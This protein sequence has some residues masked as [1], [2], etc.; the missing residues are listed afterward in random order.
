[1]KKNQYNDQIILKYLIFFSFLIHLTSINFFP[2]NFEGGYGQYSDLFNAENKILYLK[3]YYSSQFNTYIFSALGSVLNFFIPFID[4]F[5]SIKII[6]A[7]SYFF[8]G[9][10]LLNILKFYKYKYNLTFFILIIFLNSIIWSYGFRAFN[11]LFAFSLAI[12][13]LSRILKNHNNKIVFLD[14]ILLGFS[15][16][17]KSYNLILLIPLLIFFFTSDN[18]EKKIN[19]IL[20]IFVIIFLPIILLNIF[21]YN[22]LGFILAPPN[23]DVQIAIIGND[24]NRDI[25]WVI[26]NF[27]FYVGY[28]TLISLPFIFISFLS[29]IKK[30]V[31]KTLIFLLI[32]FLLSF[33]FQNFFFISSELDL[34]PFQSFIP[35]KVYKA[36]IVFLF[37]FFS[38]FL[39]FFLKYEKLTQKQSNICKTIILTILLYLFV[40]SFIKAAQRYLILPLPF[41]YL[42]IFSERQ[43]KLLIYITLIFYISINSLLLA[44]YYIVGKSTKIIFNFLKS[45]QLLE[46]TIPNV[47]IPHIHHLYINNNLILYDKKIIIKSSDYKI[48]YFNEN[49]IFSSKINIFGYEIK[50]FSVIKLK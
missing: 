4:G 33:Y 34:G 46:N 39:Y 31:K 21:T 19:K 16:A 7:L 2:T 12:F 26:N 28:L 9:F 41:I 5:Q 44:N 43:P 25:L 49:S 35:E 45:N 14:A 38:L 42:I 10:G 8:L 20:L 50:K 27:I 36:I 30:E 3:Y 29:L 15:I 23:E 6:S 17:I 47:I 48:T 24:K 37:I 13:Y 22:S 32:A 1:M 11:D 18:I 40:L